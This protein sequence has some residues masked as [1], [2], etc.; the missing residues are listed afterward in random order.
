MKKLYSTSYSN[1]RALI[2]GVNKYI[3][4]SEL[5]FAVNDAIEVGDVLNS[6]FKFPKN[7]IKIL[8]NE[9]ATFSNIMSSYMDF[10]EDNVD[11]N[12]RILF[13]F[14]GHGFTKM[15]VKRE[16][17]F[18]IPYDGTTNDLSTLISWDQ[19]IKNADLIHAKHMFFIIDACYGGLAITRTLPP[20]SMRFL[21]D[22][23]VRYTRQVLTAGKA[24]EGV[25]D[26]G[27]PIA[28]HSVFTGNLIE[29]LQ[30]K[31]QTPNGVITAN[32]IMSYVYEKVG[33]DP[34]SNQTPHYGFLEGDGDFIFNDSILQE[35]PDE[36]LIGKDVLI[37]VPYIPSKLSLSNINNVE[38]I[39]R[40]KEYISDS[41][42]KIYLND[43]VTSELR[44][45]VSLL[46][47]YNLSIVYSDA[48]EITKHLKFYEDQVENIKQIISC[49]AHWGKSDYYSMINKSIARCS[50]HLNKGD[51]LVIDIYFN[52]YPILLL[53]Y[54]AGIAAI[55]SGDYNSLK[56][57]FD[58]KVQS[59]KNIYGTHPV[60][61]PIVRAK[62]EIFEIFRKLPGYER[63]YVPISEYLYKLLQPD[64]EDLF[65]LG[66][67]Y[68]RFFDYFEIFLALNYIDLKNKSEGFDWGKGL[69][70]R[71]TWKYHSRGEGNTFLQLL[72][73]AEK[74]K[75]NWAPIKANMFYG[76]YD[77]FSELVNGLIGMVKNL[78][79]L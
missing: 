47:N 67:D 39:E 27:G 1:S 72:R 26:S 61:L 37:S 48:E 63:K 11:D 68:D 8:T 57:I 38:I 22:M 4:G 52:W 17:G 50:D 40:T 13:F 31:A 42:Y 76:F 74:E 56:N 70:G 2:I 25:S 66:N 54:S 20:G 35:Y 15:G 28:N 78:N 9:K 6:K 45:T 30:G 3:N 32:S 7:N 62:Y 51:G 33:N 41:K 75:Q 29:G 43:L 14:A 10:T 5:Q 12:D 36:E 19:L 79:W 69:F 73:E 34:F 59:D 16:T 65:F 21:K 23:M 53:L 60:A 77:R 64:L 44:K 55:A 71:F 24:N 49:I 46:R 18:L 58:V